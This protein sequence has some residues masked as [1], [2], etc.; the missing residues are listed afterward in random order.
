MRR[1]STS[2]S[3][4]PRRE[5]IMT[6]KNNAGRGVRKGLRC[7]ARAVGLLAAGLYLLFVVEYGV[8][9]LSA[10]SWNSPAGMPLFVG[11]TLAA[12][13]VVIAWRWEAIG[14]LMA[15]LG[16]M[17]IVALTALGR[18]PSMVLAG[19]VL[20]LPLLVAGTLY[21]ACCGWSVVTRVETEKAVEEQEA[22]KS[23]AVAQLKA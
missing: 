3:K 15:V 8:K 9:V 10:I 23:L 21:L 19:F 18:G 14:G 20:A 2:I 22:K 1:F 12:A 5:N 17:A 6:T 4:K 11:L 16:G 13:G 7:S